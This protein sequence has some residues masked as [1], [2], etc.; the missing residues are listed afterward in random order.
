MT[1]QYLKAHDGGGLRSVTVFKDGSEVGTFDNLAH[2][3]VT[4]GDFDGF[5]ED[6]I[7]DL[8][9]SQAGNERQQAAQ[10][11][12][13]GNVDDMLGHINNWMAIVEDASFE[14]IIEVESP[15]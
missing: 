11:Y 12:A 15:P 6:K 5:S 9:H 13:D 10:A 8:M 14:Q 1:W 4:D 3:D 2:D 7:K